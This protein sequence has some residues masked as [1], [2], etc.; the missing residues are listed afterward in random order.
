MSNENDKWI[1]SD[2]RTKKLVIRFWVKNFPKQF[3]I[4]T[5]LKDTKPNRGLVRSRRDAIAID[6]ALGRFDPTLESYKFK[7]TKNKIA[8]PVFNPCKSELDLQQI[9][10]KYVEFKSVQIEKTTI[11]T[12]YRTITKFITRLPSYSLDDAPKIRDFI[13]SNLTH[14][15]AW[16]ALMYFSRCCEWAVDSGLITNNPFSKLKIYKPKK[17]S[18]DDERQAFTIEQRDLII[19]TFEQHPLHSHYA[20]L[21]KFLF[22]TG[23]RPGEAFALT[24]ED[25]DNI[26]CRITINKSCNVHKIKKSTKNNKKRV[27][28]CRVGSKLQNLLL[29]IRPT[30]CNPANLV[31]L[32]KSNQPMNSAIMFGFWN[33]WKS[34]KSKYCGVVKSLA[35]AGKIPYLKPY[36]T[37]HTFVTWAIS[38]GTS[39]DKVA[40]WIG[41]TVETVL[42][43]YCHP[44]IIEAE[45]PD[46]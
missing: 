31:F 46:F 20:P 44:E 36:A 27:F 45:C 39:P 28:R 5:G 34:G 1:S 23:V 3:F 21:V 26:C 19:Q 29:S 7:A 30:H 24:W 8:A 12:R 33:E 6:I 25:I 37:R 43:H 16:E 2:T 11:L 18:M 13:L 41:D 22:W 15:M 32:S 38:S 4:S 42:K 9:W 40:L 35:N 10:D 17:K 14:Y